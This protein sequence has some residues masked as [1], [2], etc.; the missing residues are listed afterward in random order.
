MA[1]RQLSLNDFRNLTST[2]LDL[3]ENLNVF[4]G[5]NASGKT[6]L[7]EALHIICQGR[8]FKAH[9]IN[10]CIKHNKNSF[11]IFA[12]FDDYKAGISRNSKKTTIRINNENVHK[13]S[14]LAKKTPVKIINSSSFDLILG[15]PGIKR[16]FIDWCLF[17]VEHKYQSTWSDYKHSLKQRN[18]LLKQRNNYSELNYWDNKLS[19]LGQDIFDLRKI[20]LESLQNIVNKQFFEILKDTPLEL[21]YKPGW[22]VSKTLFENFKSTHLKDKKYGFT[23]CGIHRDDIKILSNGLDIQHIFS[24]GQIKKIAIVLLL[25][26]IF[27]VQGSK[28]SKLV[29]L[30]DDIEAELDEDSVSYILN[31]LKDKNIQLFITNIKTSPCL[32]K[33]NEEYKL[34]HVEH[35]MIKAVKHTRAHNV[36]I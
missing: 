23:Q 22:D 3:D 33:S 17:H 20:Y 36:R 15:N 1:I 6:N 4:T 32:F 19:D 12:L 30:I 11:L 10:H 13:V 26:Q 21:I 28:E 7:L 27:L 31:K 35:G 16:E 14:L 8:S 25:S 2:T 5:L 18:S 34:F 9:T 24:R 29:L